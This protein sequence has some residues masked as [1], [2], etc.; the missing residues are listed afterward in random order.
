MKSCNSQ[1]ALI[2]I[3]W[4]SAVKNQEE[5]RLDNPKKIN[6]TWAKER[7]GDR[8]YNSLCYIPK[9]NQGSMPKIPCYGSKRR[10]GEQ[11]RQVG[12]RFSYFL[13]NL[14]NSLEIIV[15]VQAGEECV[16]P[17]VDVNI[18]ARIYENETVNSGKHP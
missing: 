14:K 8:I 10:A 4:I 7:M 17:G 16:H 9:S 13:T 11:D 1:K 15:V 2:N 3:P 12:F 5:C 6:Q 18:A